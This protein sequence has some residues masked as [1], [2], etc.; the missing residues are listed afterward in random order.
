MTQIPPER[1]CLC[2]RSAAKHPLAPILAEIRVFL[3]EPGDTAPEQRP[4]SLFKL[5]PGN[6]E[7]LL[8]KD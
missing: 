2:T 3:V 1:T 4:D 6:T 7:E 8:E 5:Q